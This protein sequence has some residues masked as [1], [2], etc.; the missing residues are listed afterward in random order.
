MR[1]RYGKARSCK[2]GVRRIVAMTVERFGSI[3]GLVLNAGIV[4]PG[5]VGALANNDWD[6]MV[7]TN[8]TGPFLLVKVA[9]PHL[10]AAGGA[11][12]GVA[13]AAALS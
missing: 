7:R 11:I 9:M 2:A 6:A 12:V 5:A 4:R 8:L 1:F 10:L 13:S 3:N